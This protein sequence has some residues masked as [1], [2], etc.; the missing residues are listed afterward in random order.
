MSAI[1]EFRFDY[2]LADSWY[3]SAE[4][5]NCCKKELNS[6]FIIALK[7]NR[8]VALSLEDK[9]NKAYISIETLQSG[10]QTVEVWFEEL[11]FS[12]VACKASF[13]KTKMIQ[14]GR[15]TWS[16]VI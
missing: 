6:G 16:V 7:S 11:D 5:M 10:Q 1:G 2:V 3:S 8:K 14:S 13:Q 9:E 4:N 12:A 15:C